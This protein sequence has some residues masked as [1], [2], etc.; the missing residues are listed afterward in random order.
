MYELSLLISDRMR[1]AEDARLK[2]TLLLARDIFVS[3][4]DLLEYGE[5][6][7]N[8]EQTTVTDALYAVETACAAL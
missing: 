6:L 4:S 8:S 7:S 5:G 1:Q 3:A 2:R